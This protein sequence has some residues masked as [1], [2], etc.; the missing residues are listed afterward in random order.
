MNNLDDQIRKALNPSDAEMLGDPDDGLRVDQLVIST[1]RSRHWIMTVPIVIVSFVVFALT[2]WCLV[3]FFDA[4][5]V[6]HMIGWAMGVIT[7]T[8][9]IGFTKIWFW[10]EMQ[11]IAITREVK[12]VELLS[13]RLI[14]K[15]DQANQESLV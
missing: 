9:M 11:R 2:I 8:F 3:E 10:M 15:L 5:E 7:G 12:R 13:A 4:T 14:Q 1:F 6:Q